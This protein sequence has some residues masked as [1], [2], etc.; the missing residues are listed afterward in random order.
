MGVKQIITEWLCKLW[1]GLMTLSEL[2]VA[3]ILIVLL[4]VGIG[5]ILAVWALS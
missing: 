4:A 1:D 3:G 2:S 5:L